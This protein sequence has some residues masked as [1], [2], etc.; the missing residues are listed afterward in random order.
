MLSSFR[1]IL[2]SHA[3]LMKIITADNKTFLQNFFLVLINIQP[4]IAEGISRSIAL[5]IKSSFH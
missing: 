3:T 2:E 1:I 4:S 5:S